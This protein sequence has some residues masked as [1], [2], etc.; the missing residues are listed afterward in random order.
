MQSPNEDSW[1]NKL[2]LWAPCELLG[3]HHR[4]S[5]AKLEAVS[6]GL[7]LRLTSLWVTFLLWTPKLL[8]KWPQ[9]RR[10]RNKWQ[11]SNPLFKFEISLLWTDRQVPHTHKK[12][13]TFF[14]MLNTFVTF[15]PPRKSKKEVLVRGALSLF[16]TWCAVLWNET[17]LRQQ[18]LLKYRN[19]LWVVGAA[20]W[21]K[22]CFL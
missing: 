1:G 6:R 8:F 19:S 14:R 12:S 3:N 16:I 4:C 20:W 15:T 21:V 10:L 5:F 2:W 9:A 18:L 11:W 17:K 13:T 22:L 7:S